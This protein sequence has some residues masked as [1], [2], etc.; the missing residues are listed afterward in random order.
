MPLF[1]HVATDLLLTIAAQR[2]DD[3]PPTWAAGPITVGCRQCQRRNI[4]PMG[5]VTGMASTR[6]PCHGFQGNHQRD[7]GRRMPRGPQNHIQLLFPKDCL[8]WKISTFWCR[9]VPGMPLAE[10]TS[11]GKPGIVL[12]SWNIVA[13]F[14]TNWEHQTPVGAENPGAPHQKADPPP[15]LTAPCPTEMIDESPTH[16][17]TNAREA[18]LHVPRQCMKGAL[19]TI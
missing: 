5:I 15:R 18:G 9:R 11:A 17:S 4:V 6:L 16:Q 19:D 2:V 10:G 3:H 8:L 13:V 1:P 12:T 7:Q 14:S